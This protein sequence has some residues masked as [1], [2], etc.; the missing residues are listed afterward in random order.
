VVY[1]EV[2]EDSY[3]IVAQAGNDQL[4]FSSKGREILVSL[5]NF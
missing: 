4:D 2:V 5:A 1:S 3:L